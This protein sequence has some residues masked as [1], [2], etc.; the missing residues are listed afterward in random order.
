[1]RSCSDFRYRLEEAILDEIACAGLFSAMANEASAPV[2]KQL[3]E[4]VSEDDAAHASIFAAFLSDNEMPVC[5]PIKMPEIKRPFPELIENAVNIKLSACR[6]YS[7]FSDYAPTQAARYIMLS[8]MKEE[9][10]HVRLLE[11]LLETV[12]GAE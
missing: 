4:S 9:M 7:Y 10:H 1:M 2:Q 3:I 8:V 6:R 12:T 11:A 5:H